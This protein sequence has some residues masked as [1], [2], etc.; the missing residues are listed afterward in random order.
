MGSRVLV[1]EYDGERVTFDMEG[2]TS[3]GAPGVLLDQDDNP[4]ARRPW[5]DA[6]FSVEDSTRVSLEM[7]F[8]RRA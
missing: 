8:W 4:I 2:E 1:L 7:R 6:G 5:A 3:W